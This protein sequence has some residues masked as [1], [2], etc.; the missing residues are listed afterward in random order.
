MNAT[1]TQQ[2]SFRA[3]ID[4]IFKTFTKEGFY[5]EHDHYVS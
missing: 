4:D 1:N 2:K 3:E 5:D